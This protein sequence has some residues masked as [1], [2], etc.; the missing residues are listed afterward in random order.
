MRIISQLTP[1]NSH[2]EIPKE[3]AHFQSESK[4]FTSVTDH[5]SDIVK[6]T[7]HLVIIIIIIIMI[8][9]IIIIIIIIII[10]F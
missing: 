2:E 6:L 7:L 1:A 8:I 3:S 5:H 9:N 10:I 4:Y